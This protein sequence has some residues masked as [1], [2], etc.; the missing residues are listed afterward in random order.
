MSRTD[1]P[2]NYRRNAISII[3]DSI[4]QGSDH[5]HE[6][7]SDNSVQVSGEKSRMMSVT[8]ENSDPRLR[9]ILSRFSLNVNEEGSNGSGSRLTQAQI[10][11]TTSFPQIVK[12]CHRRPKVAS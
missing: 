5:V 1:N 6:Q 2:L 7:R 11:G 10:N 8:D 4:K 12:S 9:K 3:P